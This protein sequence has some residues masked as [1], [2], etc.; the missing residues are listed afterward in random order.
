MYNKLGKADEE[1][2]IHEHLDSV[3]EELYPKVRQYSHFLTQNSWDGD[4]IAQEAVIKALKHYNVDRINAPLLKRIAYHTWID[5]V[6][7]R[8]R[9]E[10]SDITE[11]IGLTENIDA[12]ELMDTVENLLTRF[13]PKQAVVLILKEAFQYRTNEIAELIGATDHGV[14]SIL[15]RAKKR[16]GKENDPFLKA[17]IVRTMYAMDDICGRYVSIMCT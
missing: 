13:T 7:R 1:R 16:A 17:F 9:E 10:I 15:H 6:R 8:K 4:E 11:E 2:F 3:V 12:T 5:T 14:K